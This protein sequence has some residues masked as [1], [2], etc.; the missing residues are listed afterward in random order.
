VLPAGR[1][2]SGLVRSGAIEFLLIISYAF[3]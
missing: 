3:L 1:R 2:I